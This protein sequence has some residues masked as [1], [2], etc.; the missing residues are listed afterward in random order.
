MLTWG[1][2]AANEWLKELFTT[3]A[4]GRDLPEPQVGDS[5]QFSLSDPVHIDG[6]LR[7]AGFSTVEVHPVAEPIYFGPNADDAFAFVRHLGL[8]KGLT[9][10]LDEQERDAAFNGLQAMLRR[11][12]T[13]DG[14]LLGTAALLTIARH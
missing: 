10:D 13:D 8:V 14:V 9:E 3:L 7:S 6:L 11:H 12:E 2:R 5:G 1:P 4:P